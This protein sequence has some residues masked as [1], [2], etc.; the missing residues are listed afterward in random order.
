[1]KELNAKAQRSKGAKKRRNKK[2][3]DYERLGYGVVSLVGAGAGGVCGVGLCR[4]GAA[5]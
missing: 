1:M 2:G 4:S 3:D 5:S